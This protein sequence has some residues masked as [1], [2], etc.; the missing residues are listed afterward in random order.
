MI[1]L[2]LLILISFSIFSNEEIEEVITTGTLLK[3]SKSKFSPVEI[4]TA[5]K[6]DEIGV[7]TIAEISKYLSASSGSHFQTNTMDGVD[8]GMSAITLRGLDHASTLLLINSKRQTFTGTPSY[9]GEVM[10][11]QILFQKL[12]LQKWKFLKKEQLPYM[13]L[14]L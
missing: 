1:K 12:L 3:E 10:S 11:T 6:F 5:E 14:M 9:N 2:F 7:S 13:V 4:I 8:Q